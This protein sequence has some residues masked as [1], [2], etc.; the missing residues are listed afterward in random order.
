MTSSKKFKIVFLNQMAGP[1]FRELAQ[2]LARIWS[3]SILYTGHPHTSLL[4]DSKF[5]FIKQA[6]V[7]NRKNNIYRLYSWSCYFLGALKVVHGQSGSSLL[8][9][10]SNPPFLGLLGLF[11]KITRKQKYV[12]LVYEVY[13]ELLLSL[14][15]L[16]G[17]VLSMVWNY[18]N[19]HV[20]QNAEIV[21]TIG[22]YMADNLERKFDTSKTSAK[23]VI[24]IPNWVDTNKIKPIRK[25]NNWFARKYNL[26]EKLTVLYSGNM[27]NTHNIEII[28]DVAKQLSQN[29]EIHFLFIGEGAKWDLIKNE[30][31]DDHLT[32]VTLLP[33]Q[34]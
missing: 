25:E 17:G 26:V 9:I 2:D 1:L 6:P 11:F 27:G 21:M 16:K 32:N 18:L 10:V 12:I 30:I 24:V 7:Y 23:K 3:P 5:L 31:K 14:R 33:F 20:Y 15:R 34:D 22:E 13:P 19:R 4:D 28:L 8:F 29:R